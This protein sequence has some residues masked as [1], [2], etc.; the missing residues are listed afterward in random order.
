MI[1]IRIFALLIVVTVAHTYEYTNVS[2]TF[3]KGFLIGTASSA[4]QIEGAWNIAGK[5]IILFI[6]FKP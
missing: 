5:T 2:L 3:P 1:T 4:Y 6:N